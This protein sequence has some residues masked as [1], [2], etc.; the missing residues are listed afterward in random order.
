MQA[1]QVLEEQPSAEQPQQKDRWQFALSADRL[2]AADGD[3]WLNPRW[4]QSFIDRVLPFL[5]SRPPAAAQ[6]D[7]LLATGKINVDQ[8]ALVPFML[9]H[10][11]TDAT[12]DG[13]RLNFSN[14]RAQLAKGDV[15]G[16]LRAD[17]DASPSYHLILDYSAVDLYVLTAA[18]SSLADRFAGVASGKISLSAT[19]GSRSDL[20]SSLQ[21]RGTS[22][23]TGAE[24]MNI[25]LT[26]SFADGA[27][28]PGHTTF[29]DASADFTCDSGKIEFQRLR[30]SGPTEGFTGQGIVDFSRNID[31]KFAALSDSALPRAV[32]AS[33]SPSPSYRLSGDLSEPAVTRVKQ[34]S[35][36]R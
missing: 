28:R 22:R 27:F 9:H 34:A 17:L 35:S 1:L 14:V 3:R 2:S 10:V 15:T 19:G 21:C 8:F 31:F 5:N 12:I 36:R 20:I 18:T 13:R 7:N 26:T 32:R 33:D 30:L 6:P 29:R 23:I 24:L 16:S 11:Q 4:R 25:D